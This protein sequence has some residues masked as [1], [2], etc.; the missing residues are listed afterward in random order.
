MANAKGTVVA[1]LVKLIQARPDRAKKLLH[2][3]LHKYLDMRIVLAAWYP[4]DEYLALLR[5]APKLRK[6]PPRDFFEQMGRASAREQM[7]GIYRRL[8]ENTS[9]QAAATLLSAMYDTGQKN[10][11][12]RSPGH[13][14]LEW[15]NFAIPARELCENFTGYQAERMTLQGLEEVRV[16]H[17]KCRAEGGTV[18]RWELDW[19]G[20]S[21]S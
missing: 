9:R 16:R 10:M 18:C 8:R 15:V 3:K 4:L 11:V 17:T 19:K 13:A 2:E 1:G 21:K 5:V 6:N 20:R 12:E 14:V 7:S